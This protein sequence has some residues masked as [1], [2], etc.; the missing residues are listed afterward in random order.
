M[1]NHRFQKAVAKLALV[2]I[3]SMTF[4]CGGSN[5]N[6]AVSGGGIP[7]TTTT[8]VGRVLIPPDAKVTGVAITSD[9][10]PVLVSD[11]AVDKHGFFMLQ[12]SPPSD[13]EV[14]ATIQR[15]DASLQGRDASLQSQ[16]ATSET[17]RATIRNWDGKLVGVNPLTD[18][19]ASYH[20]QHP[21]LSLA[22]VTAKIKEFLELPEDFDPDLTEFVDPE[23]AAE[24]LDNLVDDYGEGIVDLIDEDVTIDLGGD[25][26]GVGP[27]GLLGSD[28][29]KLH[30]DQELDRLNQRFLKETDRSMT[31][32]KTSS[33][34]LVTLEKDLKSV[35]GS[36]ERILKDLKSADRWA[37]GAA[38]FE[39]ANTLIGVYTLLQGLGLFKQSDSKSSELAQGIVSQVQQQGILTRFQD[40][41]NRLKALE[42]RIDAILLALDSDL[43]K[44]S[45]Q[46]VFGDDV[47]LRALPAD[48]ANLLFGSSGN[49]GMLK[50]Y[51]TLINDSR[52]YSAPVRESM[53]AFM[54]YHRQRLY[55][56][57]R[58]FSEYHTSDL[59]LGVSA[60]ELFRVT[61]KLLGTDNELAAALPELPN[62]N[63]VWDGA[64]KRFFYNKV[65]GPARYDDALAQAAAMSTE[66]YTYRLA[67][68]DELNSTF[69]GANRTGWQADHGFD[70]GP[71]FA[72]T[73]TI[74]SISGP[75]GGTQYVAEFSF[76]TGK[77]Q[78]GPKPTGFGKQDKWYN[79]KLPYM[80]VVEPKVKTRDYLRFTQGPDQISILPGFTGTG[81]GRNVS[82]LSAWGLYDGKW[83]DISHLV[84]W[85]SS[86]DQVRVYQSFSSSGMIDPKNPNGALELRPGSL[87]WGANGATSGTPTIKAFHRNHLLLGTT[88]ET[89]FTPGQSTAVSQAAGASVA[90]TWLSLAKARYR[91]GIQVFPPVLEVTAGSGANFVVQESQQSLVDTTQNGTLPQFS[92]GA[93]F[94]L[95]SGQQLVQA[96]QI[97]A[98]GIPLATAGSVTDDQVKF[99][100]SDSA[101]SVLRRP[102]GSYNISANSLLQ[103]GSRTGTLTVS[104]P[105]VDGSA[106]HQVTVNLE[107]TFPANTSNTVAATPATAPSIPPPLKAIIIDGPA[108][109]MLG[110]ERRELSVI[111]IDAANRQ[112]SLDSFP[113]TKSFLRW[114][115]KQLG[116][117]QGLEET[118]EIS[119]TGVVL[120]KDPSNR[121]SFWRVTA[122]YTSP[123]DYTTI[124]TPGYDFEHYNP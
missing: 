70:F 123:Y 6:I 87:L 104:L 42:D 108:V 21:E 83:I 82:A 26:P 76:K 116:A 32:R 49:D 72:A 24:N 110:L 57:I 80:L 91:T 111:G 37:K 7:D 115:I 102:D 69:G 84:D 100:V 90:N 75:Q 33:A 44:G 109:D 34:S 25:G 74:K 112:H 67:S 45:R 38:F 54:A 71:G 94:L 35:V 66:S 64:Q 1:K 53:A 65:L 78:V 121:V 62:A 107:G 88:L 55:Q 119:S 117:R 122:T 36:E 81:P 4:G 106:V 12:S 63:W 17:W 11:F 19:I 10:K 105:G 124:T 48:Y 5:A 27:E 89:T 86:T 14:A 79:E 9:G 96:S 52:L 97:A 16:D 98:L 103:G 114:Q 99:E 60:N 58:I 13:F 101:L 85:S 15:Q 43:A 39:A 46:T 59:A 47:T 2:G 77:E 28:L 18:L 29:T 30:F 93:N 31:F 20:A 113:A 68:F 51:L 120:P 56:L 50:Q 40:N 22:E 73:P 61:S 3:G 118:R 8:V 23:L 41:S 92:L 95:D